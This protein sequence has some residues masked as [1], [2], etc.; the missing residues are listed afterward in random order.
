MGV[1]SY[2]TPASR[3]PF[4]ERPPFLRERTGG[5]Y[6]C[7]ATTQDGSDT[8]R[9]TSS[10]SVTVVGE[11]L[12][13]AGSNRSPLQ[14]SSKYRI[15]DNGTLVITNVDKQDEEK[16]KCTATNLVGQMTTESVLRLAYL[17]QPKITSKPKN[18]SIKE[19][20][21][22]ILDCNKN[23]TAY[24]DDHLWLHCNASGDPKPKISW[25]KEAQGGDK[26]DRERFILFPNGTLHIKKVQFADE[27]RYYC[28]AAN[29]AEMKQ[30]KFSL[31][32][33]AHPVAEVSKS[34]ASMARTIGIAVG[35]AAAYIV[36]VVGLMIYCKG[37]RA[38]Q[39]RKEEVLP[40]ECENLNV[41]G[42]VEHKDGEGNDMTMNPIYRSHPGYDKMEFPRHDLEAIRSLGNGAY[43]R[44]FLARAS[45]IRDGEKE[46]M[47]VVK[48]LVSNDDQ[49]REDF[50][51]EMEALC[52][53][54]HDNVV[55]LLGV[56][57]DEEPFYMIFESLEKGDLKQYL[58]SCYDNG[59]STLNSNQKLAICGQLA[60]GMNYLSSQHFVHKDLAARNCMVGR[61]MQIKIGFLSF[62]YDLYNKEYYR[63][64]NVQIPLRWMPPEAIFDDDFSEKS[65]VWSFGVLVW[66]IY[67]LGQLP[68][69][70]RSNE[71][72]LKCVK[73]D[74]RLP[75]PDNCPDTVL[76][77]LEKCWEGNPLARPSFAELMDDVAGISVD[78]HV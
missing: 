69:H 23:T 62:S 48:A 2:H 70:D 10:L 51:K 71:E 31:K 57:K 59:R 5:E 18:I 77:V 22:A 29:H 42:D 17:E 30:S 27:G 64:N 72:V 55:T 49:V 78:S 76:E 45:G 38:R 25:S 11:Y 28:I 67:T 4:D 12:W 16:Y 61:D 26:L 58:L 47:V 56:C 43:G 60:T 33:Q 24:V 75:K 44:A 73:D 65:D 15:H 35:C 19:D 37:R 13:Y 50:N 74:L 20:E 63:F 53:L 9:A 39:N 41:N 7:S 6:S 3:S 68:Y 40:P 21:K 66:E 32:V 52:G 46:T 1:A 34:T 36:L 14:S 8:R 54:Q